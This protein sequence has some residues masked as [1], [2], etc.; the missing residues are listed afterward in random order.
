MLSRHSCLPVH[1][2]R[3]EWETTIMSTLR[4]HLIGI[5]AAATVATTTLAV[6]PPASAMWPA[7]HEERLPTST[8]DSATCGLW[9][10]TR[11]SP[12]IGI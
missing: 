7:G 3:S 9:L 4:K 12:G 11:S 10:A 6:P 5:L 2:S 8:L 1:R